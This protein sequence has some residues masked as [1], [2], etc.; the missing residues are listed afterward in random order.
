MA[1]TA[2]QR[3]E[4]LRRQTHRIEE[5]GALGTDDRVPGAFRA[6]DP[7]V[8]DAPAPDAGNDLLGGLGDGV[9]LGHAAVS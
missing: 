8:G 7:L 3:R 4:R 5:D 9:R 6:A 1:E 2:P